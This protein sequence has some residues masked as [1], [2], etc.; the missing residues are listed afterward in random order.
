MITAYERLVSLGKELQLVSDSASLLGWDQEVLLPR[1]GITY[2]AEQMAWFSGYLHERFTAAEVGEWIVEA[3]GDSSLAT[4]PVAAANLR[5][6][7][8]DYD[9]ATCLPTK[10]VQDFAEARVHSQAAWAEARKASD[11]ANF[12][13]HLR[14]LVELSRE[15]A[16]RWGF[17]ET[18][19]D[20]LLDRFEPGSTTNRRRPRRTR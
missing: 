4:D 9:H 5:E 13:P 11:F 3:A 14:K 17:E 20:A 10:L 18:V 6:W 19:Y 15:H 8:H 7:R 16:E 1:L 12:A 2:R